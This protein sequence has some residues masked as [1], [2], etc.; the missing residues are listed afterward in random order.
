MAEMLHKKAG[1]TSFQATTQRSR[2]L[3]PHHFCFQDMPC[4]LQM[5]LA[6]PHTPLLPCPFTTLARQLLKAGRSTAYHTSIPL[7]SCGGCPQH[8]ITPPASRTHHCASRMR[9][10]RPSLLAPARDRC[11]ATGRPRPG[12][13]PAAPARPHP[14]AALL[15]TPC[16]NQL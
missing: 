16:T 15:P 2:M 1:I 8:I 7:S 6:L 5:L 14:A 3:R 9:C 4:H 12:T 11:T 10:S 13:P